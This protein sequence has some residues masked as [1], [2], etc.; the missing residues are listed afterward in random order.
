MNKDLA[1]EFR[2]DDEMEEGRIF[3]RNNFIYKFS[4]DNE[5]HLSIVKIKKYA[6]LR[7]KLDL[8]E[9]LCRF[10]VGSIEKECFANCNVIKEVILPDKL[11]VIKY[12]TFY[13]CEKLTGI[14]LPSELNIISE[15]A[16][17]GC[18]NLQEV[19][20]PSGVRKIEK[21][22]F[23]KCDNVRRVCINKETEARLGISLQEMGFPKTVEIVY[24][25]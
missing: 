24:T 9:I 16:F 23:F 10:N 14:K 4:N 22:A 6:L 8:K 15:E 5:N 20:I 17:A 18:I 3:L 25:I 2:K 13:R 12:R 1:N 11:K 19:N 21:N 7:E